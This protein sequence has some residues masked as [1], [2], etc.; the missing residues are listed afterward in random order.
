MGTAR[1]ATRVSDTILE[2]LGL[3]E[4]LELLERVVLDLADALAGDAE[5]AADLLERARLRAREPDA[6]LDHLAVTLGQ[7]GQRVLDVL[8]A[9]RDLGGVEGRLGLLVLDEVA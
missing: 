5:R 1:C 9:E 7:R 3:R 4:R 8:P 2:A 6:E